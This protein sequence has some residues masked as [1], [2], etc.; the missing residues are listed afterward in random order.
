MFA[1]EGSNV[2]QM[3][4][5]DDIETAPISVI[6]AVSSPQD[7]VW[8]GLEQLM[9]GWDGY[10]DESAAAVGGGQVTG[11]DAPTQ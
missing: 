4:H 11:A 5:N 9:E 8:S 3:C 6:V 1:P 2:P 10:P 7:G